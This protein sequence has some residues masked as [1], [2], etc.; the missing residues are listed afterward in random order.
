MESDLVINGKE[1]KDLG[2]T[3]QND[4]SSDKQ[5]DKTTGKLISSYK[6]LEWHAITSMEGYDEETDLC[7]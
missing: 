5:I 2:I 3:F 1:E 4:L 6:T 7:Q